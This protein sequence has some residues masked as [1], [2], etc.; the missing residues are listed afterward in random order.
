MENATN[1]RKIEMRKQLNV[2]FNCSFVLKA[3]PFQLLVWFSSQFDAIFH[4]LLMKRFVPY[5]NGFSL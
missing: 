3:T 5:K 1:K 4:G 2:S